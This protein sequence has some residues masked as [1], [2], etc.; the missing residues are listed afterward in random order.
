MSRE[1]YPTRP[2]D[3]SHERHERTSEIQEDKQSRGSKGQTW[4]LT[5]SDGAGFGDPWHALGSGQREVLMQ[6]P[7][8]DAIPG[9]GD[10]RVK[11]DS[12]LVRLELCVPLAVEHSTTEGSLSR[13]S[14]F[15]VEPDVGL[16]GRDVQPVR[17]KT[18]LYQLIAWTLFGTWLPGIAAGHGRFC[19]A[20]KWSPRSDA[21]IRTP[22][23][24]CAHL[25]AGLSSPRP[26]CGAW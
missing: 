7:K 9:L 19:S 22:S 4:F 6:D 10:G 15:G 2:A 20:R 17:L 21:G 16:L 12:V 24:V 11:V 23:L 26:R 3:V 25:S 14:A 18:S 8:Y 13:L 1:A 5:A